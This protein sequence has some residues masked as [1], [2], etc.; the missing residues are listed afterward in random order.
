GVI[1]LMFALGLEFSLGKLA[2][3]GPTAGPTALLQSGLMTWL[4]FLVGRA[5]GWTPL[6]SVFIGAAIAI[7]STTIIAK[8]FDEQAIGGRQRE[9]VVG[10]LLIEDLI[11]VVFMAALTAIATGA[12]LSTGALAATIGRLTAFLIA[13]LVVGMLIVPRFVRAV[14][15]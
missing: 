14:M 11:A 12:G 13:L 6:E 3:V 15:R 10:I 4:G 7:S 2:R 5:F 8:V 1:L 9:L